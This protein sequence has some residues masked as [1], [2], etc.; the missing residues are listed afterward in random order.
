[1][2]KKIQLFVESVTHT[3]D[4]A[5]GFSTTAELIAPST[6]DRRSNPWMVLAGDDSTT[7][8]FAPSGPSGTETQPGGHLSET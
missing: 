6:T 5:S 7:A 8:A 4:R 2:S 1:M 3:W